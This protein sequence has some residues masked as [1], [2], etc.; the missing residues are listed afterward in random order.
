VRIPG[1]SGW[2]DVQ[3]GFSH[4]VSRGVRD[5]D[6][7]TVLLKRLRQDFPDPG[8]VAALINEYE[9]LVS[10][11][12]EGVCRPLELLRLDG[13]PALLL[14]DAR[15]GT[16]A[17]RL[18]DGPM[19]RE[20][21]L[22]VAG[23]LVQVVA[24]LHDE[25]V[26]H[27]DLTP[28]NVLLTEYGPVVVDFGLAT[29]L[30]GLQPGPSR[31]AGT[32][33]YMA[34]EQTGRTAQSVDERTDLYALGVNF[35]EMLTGQPPFVAS[36]AG[37]LLHA[38]LAR[39]PRPPSSVDTA[40]PGPI[41]AL[42]LRL[43]AKNPAD[44]YQSAHGLRADLAELHARLDDGRPLDDFQPGQ[45]D[46]PHRLLVPQR[47]HGR[48]GELARMLGALERAGA[49]Q[50][51][52][53]VVEGTTG[54]GKSALLRSLR[55]AAAERGGLVGAGSFEQLDRRR[56]FAGVA[57]ALSEI[58]GALLASSEAQL[59]RWR[60][61]LR[62]SLQDVLGPL[63]ELV[64]ELVQI[65]GPLPP[66]PAASGPLEARNRLRDSV[67]ALLA[68][69]ASDRRPVVLLFDDLQWI[70]PAS[71]DLLDGVAEQIED[72]Q[73][74]VAVALR[75]D[76]IGPGHPLV[77][78]LTRLEGTG[79]LTERIVLGPLAP[80]A[81][82]G[83]VGEVLALPPELVTELAGPVGSSAEGNP[84][85][86]LRQL[87]SL[88]ERGLLT[89][90]SSRGWSWQTE[91]LDELE[92][93]A[94]LI[95][96]SSDLTAS[97][98]GVV[99]VLSAAAALGGQFSLGL[100]ASVLERP[101]LELARLLEQPL[102]RGLLLPVEGAWRLP[103]GKAVTE[104]DLELL[105][106]SF[107]FAHGR[108]QEAALGL[109]VEEELPLLHLRVAEALIAEH[110][111]ANL[112]LA[113]EHLWLAGDAVLAWGRREEALR[114]AGQAAERALGQSAAGAALRYATAGLS[115]LG[116]DPWSVDPAQ[117]TRLVRLAARAA[118]AVGDP[119]GAAD[120]LDRA[121][122][123]AV[124]P[125]EVGSLVGQRVAQLVVAGEHST[126]IAEG[127]R[128]LALLGVPL[129]EAGLAKAAGREQAA[130]GA[131]MARLHP[132]SLES[133]PT[134]C[135]PAVLTEMELL[136]ALIPSSFF[137]EQELFTLIIL[138]MVR[139]TLEHGIGPHSGYPLAF[140]GSIGI[141]EGSN[142]AGRAMAQAG[143]AHARA[144][145]DPAYLCRVLFIF[146]H[147]VNHWIA[148]LR[149]NAEL[150]HEAERA[151][152]LA[153]DH[154]WA[155]YAAAGLVLNLFP[156]GAPL[157]TVLAEID[158]ATPFLAR[159]GNSPMIGMLRGVRQAARCLRGETRPGTF[160]DDRFDE[161]DFLQ[162]MGAVP[163]IGVLY[164]TCRL[165]VALYRGD[166]DRAEREAAAVRELLPYARG[167]IQVAEHALLEG[168]VQAARAEQTSGAACDDLLAR[169]R[170]NVARLEGWAA[171]EPCNFLHKQRLLEGAIQ[172]TL[173]ATGPALDAL[174]EAAD[175]ARKEGFLQDA[176]LANEMAGWLM[177]ADGK[178]TPALAYL[179]AARRAWILWGAPLLA[180]TLEDRFEGLRLD[181]PTV[182]ASMAVSMT[183][184]GGESYGSGPYDA[185]ASGV[186]RI[187]PDG[188]TQLT[189]RLDLAGILEA[190]EAI[191]GELVL[192]ELAR[193]LL[194]IVVGLAG[195]ERGALVLP[196]GDELVVHSVLDGQ[197]F[198]EPGEALSASTEVAP[199]IVSYAARTGDLVVVDDARAD[200]RFRTDPRI[201]Q[202][203]TRSVLCI[204]ALRRKR[205]V[206]LLYL[207]N[208]LVV[209]SFLESRARL[210][211]LMATQIAIALENAALFERIGEQTEQRLEAERA[212]QQA[213]KMESI[214]RL[215]GGVAHDFNNLLGI[216]LGWS[217]LLLDRDEEVPREALEQIARAAERGAEL[218]RQLLAFSKSAMARPQDVYLDE[219][220]AD[221]ARMVDRL[222]GDG[223]ELEVE[224]PPIS[225]RPAIVDPALLEQVVV[226][227]VVNARDAMPRGG[228]IRIRFG[229]VT[230]E[231]DE[232]GLEAGDYVFLEVQDE[233]E[234][235]DAEVLPRIFEP[236]F[237][238]KPQGKGTGLG[239]STCLGIA[240]Q[241]GGS[242]RVRPGET[243]GTIFELILP[244]GDDEAATT[245]TSGIFAD[246]T[247]GG[248]RLVLLV[249][250]DPTLRHLLA[251]ALKHH[252]FVVEQAESGEAA[253]VVLTTGLR[254][255]VLLT[256]LTMPGMDGFELIEE[257]RR[258]LPGLPAAVLSGMVDLP[259]PHLGEPPVP[260]LQ[261]PIRPDDLASALA[262]QLLPESIGPDR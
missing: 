136:D 44:R 176:A 222:L 200:S 3:V 55:G 219:R 2:S 240:Q 103:V 8:A 257:A 175:R 211:G 124:G 165:R 95:D 82:V 125:L 37:E 243:I 93:A 105:Q 96:L 217:R 186:H 172:R 10:F 119:V 36:S 19:D 174:D 75:P 242:L 123:H 47:L 90:D 81:V 114:L 203:D 86:I 52:L 236:F 92:L 113:I 212:L 179:Q 104:E 120:L 21:F 216:I 29:R 107:R 24:R 22:R 224:A 239:L 225:L 260:L 62:E 11:D 45:A 228:T 198:R 99:Q 246:P 244:A 116:E 108:I 151:G 72:E 255:A 171:V 145:G 262:R 231:R 204:P 218:T 48:K 245:T 88:R 4:V 170:A 87:S 9:L 49:G 25:G 215:A 121:E 106:P 84:Q 1:F 57:D 39:R 173:G 261:K 61:R 68:T 138:R 197:G 98:E 134:L 181:D 147:H 234:G 235:I 164:R 191:A 226:N 146:A 6:G 5:A 178:R 34:P 182:S 12:F 148:P 100:L 73:I 187:V 30:R 118:V 150:F 54:L 221:V 65:T 220:L 28:S 7:Q 250:D 230:L 41:S 233:G 64:P 129:T 16:L 132:V 168:L 139:L 14:E 194:R 227:L 153:G 202:R 229:N 122:R 18:L 56:P 85:L 155:G 258:L 190:S 193:R 137:T 76:E 77:R 183:S 259:S 127:R 167:M 46:H 94:D 135:D 38:H 205:L 159:T 160:D 207:E 15:G 70:D 71:L 51:G 152:L 115:W 20:E 130:V 232:A 35:Y 237:T 201:R 17:E 156:S 177:F 192:E 27:R 144:Q 133:L 128:G 208:D 60:R 195:A 154:Q 33:A 196:V 252:G 253:M 112:L 238:T 210:L 63:A 58:L 50:P 140:Q 67:V 42:V 74:L 110:D 89:P 117:A 209:G 26:L 180:A 157:A 223:F 97:P 101:R 254:P 251:V 256:D 32:L 169:A 247:D 249:E 185:V 53:V 162:G 199:R 43:L 91:G 31:L 163:A 161:E 131:L 126:A 79:G 149:G 214:G 188:T 109:S 142:E 206:A 102:R 141:A 23:A 80:E 158:R 59:G 13:L 83:L 248:G 66:T 213:Q 40:I 111:D 189:D 184:S 143:L 69:L 241:S 78:T 166:L